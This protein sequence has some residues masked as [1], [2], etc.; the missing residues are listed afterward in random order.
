MKLSF[1]VSEKALDASYHVAKLITCQK[2]VYYRRNFIKTS[3]PRNCSINA[4]TNG[5]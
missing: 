1:A 2:T 3:M 4:W 5:S